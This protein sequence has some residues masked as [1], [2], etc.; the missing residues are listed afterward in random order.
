ME[1]CSKTTKNENFEQSHS[2]EKCKR[3]P[4]GLLI[5]QFDAENRKNL[6][7]DALTTSKSFVNKSHNAE[8]TSNTKPS[9]LSS[10]KKGSKTIVSKG[11]TLW[12]HPRLLSSKVAMPR[13]IL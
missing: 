13:E 2:A 12:K 1:K 3:A 10:N 9:E 7:G 6:R 8:Q 11:G 4:F 5:V